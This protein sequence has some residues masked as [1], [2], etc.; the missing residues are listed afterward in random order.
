[1]PILRLSCA[2]HPTPEQRTRLIHRLTATVVEELQVPAE[3]INVLIECIDPA[4]WGVGGR[5]LDAVFAEWQQG[6]G[7]PGQG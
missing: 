1:M 3:A 7:T 5:G 2:K 4:D 6:T